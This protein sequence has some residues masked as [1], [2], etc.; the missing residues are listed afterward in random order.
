MTTQA[1][2]WAVKCNGE[3][4][5]RTV[6]PTRRAAIV[7]WLV[8]AKGM[9]VLAG[10]PDKDIDDGWDLKRTSGDELIQVMITEWG[11]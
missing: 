9:A 5:A 10:T 8:V 7:N 2:G 3:I 6:S 1:N 4:D 11:P